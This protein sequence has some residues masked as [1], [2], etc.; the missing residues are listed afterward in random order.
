MY[1]LEIEKKAKKFLI[2]AKNKKLTIGAWLQISSTEVASIVASGP[3]D[4]VGIDMEH[5]NI[6]ISKLSEILLAIENQRKLS[7]IRISSNKDINISRYLDLGAKGL[8]VPNAN[9]PEIIK[10]IIKKT[11]YKKGTRGVGYSRSNS[12]GLK[13]KDQMKYS[14]KIEI[15]PMIESLLAVNNLDK[16]LDI[17]EINVLFIGP[18][19]LE[20]SLIKEK[21]KLKLQDVLKIIKK[22]NYK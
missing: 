12:Y 7:F 10:T 4:W 2:K 22:K 11:K 13:L 1:N 9:T 8:I 15:I 17:K 14:D 3:F 19:D 5:G 16:I 20:N 21:S 6:E 18:K